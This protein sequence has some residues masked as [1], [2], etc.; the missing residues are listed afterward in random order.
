[1]L[2]IHIITIFK[3]SL[4]VEVLTLNLEPMQEMSLYIST[5]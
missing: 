1:M 2:V 5:I 4:D 3:D